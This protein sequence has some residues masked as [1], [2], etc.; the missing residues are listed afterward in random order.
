MLP[1]AKHLQ[2]S[3]FWTDYA[4]AHPGD[5]DGHYITE[6]LMH[7]PA[8]VREPNASWYDVL[9]LSAYCLAF[10]DVGD[11][12]PAHEIL[13]RI[14]G[15]YLGSIAPGAVGRRWAASVSEVA[16]RLYVE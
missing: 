3:D 8:K 11:H 7:W 10:F 4:E 13:D 12:R 15:P 1:P 5:W 16:W 14:S 2:P 6:K 9:R